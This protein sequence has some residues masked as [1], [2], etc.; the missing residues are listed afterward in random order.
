MGTK[1]PLPSRTGGRGQHRQSFS[2]P[3]VPGA[4]ND[5]ILL[6]L[7]CPRLGVGV[8]TF[9]R[10]FRGSAVARASMGLIPLPFWMSYDQH[11]V[12]TASYM[13]RFVEVP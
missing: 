9:P 10:R 11:R 6:P 4:S 8:G 3:D 12:M 1:K 2:V 13:T 7:I 5:T